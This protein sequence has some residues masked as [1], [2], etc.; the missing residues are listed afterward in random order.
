MTKP[1]LI[2]GASLCSVEDGPQDLV[3]FTAFRPLG[4]FSTS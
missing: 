1:R 2:A 3:T 4:V